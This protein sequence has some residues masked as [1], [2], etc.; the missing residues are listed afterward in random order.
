[1]LG[2][3]QLQQQARHGTIFVPEHDEPV[4]QR[5]RGVLVE[6]LTL[7]VTAESSRSSSR[8][9]FSVRGSSRVHNRLT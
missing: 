3:D 4:S 6:H 2:T 1:M 7:G 8:A 9:V 5:L